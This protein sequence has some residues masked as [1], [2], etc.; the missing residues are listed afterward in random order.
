LAGD[1][2]LDGGFPIFHQREEKH[3][4][5]CFAVVQ[6]QTVIGNSR[7]KENRIKALFF[8]PFPGVERK[9]LLGKAAGLVYTDADSAGLIQQS[10]SVHR[11]KFQMSGTLGG[12]AFQIIMCII[13]QLNPA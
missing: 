4:F 6:N 2:F 3:L 5:Q 1:V 8:I 7:V 11:I 12:H 10:V 13:H 9:A